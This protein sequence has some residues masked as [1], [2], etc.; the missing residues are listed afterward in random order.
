MKQNRG[1]LPSLQST[2]PRG[3]QKTSWNARQQLAYLVKMPCQ[4][5]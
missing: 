3:Y 4:H 1:Y 2:L 5:I